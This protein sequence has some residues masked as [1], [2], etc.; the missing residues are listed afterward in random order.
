MGGTKRA[1]SDEIDEDLHEGENGRGVA[2]RRKCPYLDTINHQLLDFDFEKV[3]A[4]SLSDQHVYAC[5]VCGKFF[6]GRGKST[7]AFTHSVQN[8]HHVFINLQ[9]DRIYCLPDN[10]EVV[11]TAL[12]PIKLALRPRFQRDAIAALDTNRLLAQDAFG[13]AYLP[14]FIGLNNLKHT[15][16]INVVVQAL[17][18]VAPLRDF[19]LAASDTALLKTKSQLVVR[20]GELL[21]KMWSPHNFKNTVRTRVVSCLHASVFYN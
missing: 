14:G 20:F 13:V 4:V 3:C 6:Q 7:H 12:E 15:D 11:D 9:N 18:H 1:A 17:A 21:R 2:K 5:L 16:Y 10:Y 19:F 8:G